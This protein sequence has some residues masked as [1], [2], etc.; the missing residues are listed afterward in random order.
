VEQHQAGAGGG[1]GRTGAVARQGSR[2]R[3]SRR[4]ACPSARAEAPAAGRRCGAPA[5]AAQI[6]CRL[7]P[8]SQRGGVVSRACGALQC[9]C[10]GPSA[11]AGH[12]RLRRA[13]RRGWRGA[14]TRRQPWA[15]FTY[16]LVASTQAA[17]R[18][19]A[20]AA[21]SM[22]SARWC[23]RVADGV[24][25]VHLL[26]APPGC[27]PLAKIAS[28]L[29]RMAAGPTTRGAARVHADDL[30]VV[31]PQPTSAGRCRRAAAPR[32]TGPRCRRARP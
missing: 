25:P 12:G 6:V 28:K 18:P 4:R 27:A 23:T 8:G 15:V 30:V 14:P 31:G 19:S 11:P 7:P 32:R 16:T 21:R 10:R 3:R 26:A 13:A 20:G 5:A 29:A 24:Q 22:R 2:R 17:A 9:R 1:A